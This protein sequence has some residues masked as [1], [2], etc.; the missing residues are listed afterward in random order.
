MS[1]ITKSSSAKCKYRKCPA[2]SRGGALKDN[3]SLDAKITEVRFEHLQETVGLGNRKPRLSWMVETATPGWQ[4]KSYEVQAYGLNGQ[5]RDQSSRVESGQS[6]LVAWPFAPLTSREQLNVRIRVWDIAERASSWSDLC[7]IEAALLDSDD[8]TAS[9]VTPD[10]EEETSKPQ[11]S[12]MMRREFD[13]RAGLTSARLYIT[14]LGLYAAEING[15]AV[16]DHVMAPGWTSY[17]HRLRYQIFDVTGL[18]QEGRN[19]I[20][21]ILGDGWY[22]G[23]LGFGGLRRNLYGERLALLAQLEIHYMDGTSE[24][25]VSDESWRA[26]T[27]PILAADIYNGETYDARLERL[28]W[29]SPGYEDGDWND[30]RP[31][32]YDLSKLFAPLGPPVRRTEIVAAVA[33][34]R[35]PSGRTIVDFGQNLVGW[36]RLTVQGQAGQTI[37]LRHAE[38]LE[39]GELCVRP[40]R[41]AQAVD[42][43]TLR[44]D[45]IESWEPRFTFHGF[46]YAE[47]DGWPGECQVSDLRAVVC[48]SDMKR[49][50]WFDCSDPLLNQLHE[51]VVWSMRG[52]F[53]SIPTDCP[54]RDERLGWTGDI[55][56]FAPTASFLYDSAGFLTSWLADLAAEQAAKGVVPYVVPD[57]LDPKPPAAAWG[58]AAVIVPWVLYQRYGDRDILATQF[59]SMRGWVD[60]LASIAGDNKL[61]DTGFQ[62][63][64]WLDPAAPPDNP[65]AARTDKHLLAT[66]YFARST[67]LVSQIAELL[68]LANEEA[69]YRALA[70]E[71]RH[72]FANEYVTPS[73]RLLSDSE[74]AYA[75]ALEFGLLPASEQRQHAAERLSALVEASGYHISTGFVGTPLICDV[76]C[77]AG[78]VDDAYILLLQRDCPSWLYPVTMGAT[79]IWERWDSLRPDGSVNPGEMTSFNHYALGAIA[80]WLHRVVGGLAP[81]EPGYGR[82]E[83][84]PQPGGNLTHASSQHLTPNGMAECAWMIREGTMEVRVMVPPSVTAKV[85]LPAREESIEVG[86]G[87]YHWSYDYE[88]PPRVR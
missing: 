43:Y 81:L 28:G 50:G 34:T 8:W 65:G 45:G 49:T 6:T 41:A 42:R 68:G 69:T 27:G 60:L 37:T 53:L 29:S 35:S 4:Q 70:A 64:D 78:R 14:A 62:F 47:I 23:W 15:T 31:L 17:H 66:A 39:D 25:I 18:L 57:I 38:V 9:F 24:Q 74:T 10:W 80:D 16:S 87:T 77:A 13:V 11:P 46:R 54:Q 83:V 56:V 36:I 33:I 44:G 52:N 40:L 63:G 82:I 79:T 67:E 73:G 85:T 22:R 75:L 7:S 1:A 26:A 61:W 30:V 3:R 5:L 48:H 58:D 71:V 20:G 19:A 12:P 76:L 2:N 84:R 32:Q 72:A 88:S 55:Q 21:A 59:E 86:S 51:N